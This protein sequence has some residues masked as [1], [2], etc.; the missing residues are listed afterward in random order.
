MSPKPQPQED[1]RTLNAYRHGP[2]GQVRFCTPADEQAS[3]LRAKSDAKA[4]KSAKA[5]HREVT[6]QSQFPTPLQREQANWRK[7]IE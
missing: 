3:A 7:Q 5:P 1:P 2:T 4:E 6:E